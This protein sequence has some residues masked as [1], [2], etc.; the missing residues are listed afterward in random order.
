MRILTVTHFF[1]Q[2]GG[3][4]ER[5]AG[6][7]CLAFQ[8]AG[9]DAVWAAS[10][11]SAEPSASIALPSWN[12]IERSTGIPMPVPGPRALAR[13]WRAVGR[14]DGVV[15]HD[16]LYLTSMAAMVAA[17]LRHKPVILVQHIGALPFR[18]RLVRGVVTLGNRLVSRT[19]LSVANRV[20]FISATT[21]AYFDGLNFSAPARLLFNGVDPQVFQ[22]LHT[23]RDALRAHLGLPDDKPVML[24]VGRFVEKKGLATIAALAKMRPDLFFVLAG[25]GP[26]VPESWDLA[27]V[28]VERGLAGS[29]LADFYRSADRL[30]LPSVGEGFPLVIQEAMA[31]GLPVIC[32]SESAA[33]DPDATRFLTG[34]PISNTNAQHNAQR[35]ALAMDGPVM[36]HA[37]RLEMADYAR[38]TYQ[39]PTMAA[40][41]ID[42]FAEVSH[43]GYPA[44][45]G[46]P[47][48]AP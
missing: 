16:T 43:V 40:A 39:W 5:V 34:L 26:I 3:G 30:L 2:H 1:E 25:K 15:I 14:S 35:I 46:R 11:L 28:R 44:P 21:M 6:Q 29:A 23:P 7:L 27:N 22:P 18:N 9:H 32:G 20:L 10:G 19:M 4:I 13:L 8:A 17:R 24:F 12:G 45:T 48:E 41:I 38:R 47:V 31:C 42:M 33:A 37:D 36:S